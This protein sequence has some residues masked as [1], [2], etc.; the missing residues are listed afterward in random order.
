MRKYE[1]LKNMG[2]PKN[3]NSPTCGTKWDGSADGTV[4]QMNQLMWDSR[5]IGTGEKIFLIIIA[6]GKYSCLLLKYTFS[7]NQK[8]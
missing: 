4:E 2:Q 1:Q 8:L 5:K 7:I 6:F 3:R